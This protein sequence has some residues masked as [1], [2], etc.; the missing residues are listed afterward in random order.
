MDKDDTNLRRLQAKFVLGAAAIAPISPF[1]FMQ[2]SITRWKVGVLPAAAGP[3]TGIAGEG[4]DPARLYVIGE[5]TVAGLGARTHELALAGRFAKH[6]SDHIKR[7]VEWDV[8]G[9]NGVTARRTIDELVPHMP[10]KQFDYILLGI[11]GNDVMRLSSPRRWRED[12][13]EL[14]GIM[15][16]K[17]PDAVI[18]ISN[19]P[20]IKYTHAI[21]PPSKQ[22]LWQLSQ[23]HDA[24]IKEFTRD[25]ERVFYYPQ[26]VEV[27][28]DGFF[29]DGIHPSEQGYNDWSAA[30]IKFFT[31]NYEW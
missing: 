26:P 28:L 29:A 12:M 25:M 14:I 1:L 18:F 21:P 30:M 3:L 9:K 11:G 16:R 20:M 5:S 31:E 27:R 22:L 24:N 4:D 10:D 13:T 7:P 23:M 19:C 6:L 2:G 15:R 8:L 17:H